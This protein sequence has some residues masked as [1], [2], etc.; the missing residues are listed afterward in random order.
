MYQPGQNQVRSLTQF[1]SNYFLQ[2]KDQSKKCGFFTNPKKGQLFLTVSRDICA[3]HS[4]TD[5]ILVFSVVPEAT[6]ETSRGP[7]KAVISVQKS[8][9][10]PETREFLEATEE[11]SVVCDKES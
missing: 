4:T 7:L 9:S 8:P 3:Q 2:S 5:G 1:Y 10:R 11:K 6:H